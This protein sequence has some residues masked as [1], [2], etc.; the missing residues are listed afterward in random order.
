M[1]GIILLKN[2]TYKDKRLYI[3]G[4]QYIFDKETNAIYV[5]IEHVLLVIAVL[6]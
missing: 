4:T 2:Y 6:S 5:L 1:S 3:I